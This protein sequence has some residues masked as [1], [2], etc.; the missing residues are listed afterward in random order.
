M[1][2]FK[3]KNKLMIVRLIIYFTY[4]KI[5]AI[6]IYLAREGIIHKNN[7]NLVQKICR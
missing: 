5:S 2:W 3:Q 4:S 6:S 1:E 7:N